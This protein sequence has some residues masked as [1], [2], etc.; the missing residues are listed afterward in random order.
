[1]DAEKLIN[2][3]NH[4]VSLGKILSEHKE[5]FSDDE[6]NTIEDAYFDI[7]ESYAEVINTYSAMNIAK[8]MQNERDKS[9]SDEYYFLYSS[10]VRANILESINSLLG[11]IATGSDSEVL[12]Q[13]LEVLHEMYS[14]AVESKMKN[15]SLSDFPDKGLKDII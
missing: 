13:N 8:K 12:A 3:A 2:V 5:K 4:I 14:C 10:E 6:Y 1:M 7:D 11:K 9:I 15:I